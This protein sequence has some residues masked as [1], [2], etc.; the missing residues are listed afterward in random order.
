MSISYINAQSKIKDGRSNIK[1]TKILIK[2]EQYID[3][4]YWRNMRNTQHTKQ[5]NTQ[6]KPPTMETG[7]TSPKTAAHEGHVPSPVAPHCKFDTVDPFPTVHGQKRRSV[8]VT[9][10]KE[11]KA[12]WRVKTRRRALT[13]DVTCASGKGCGRRRGMRLGGTCLAEVG[14][15]A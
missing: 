12:L 9:R 14:G 15:C 6:H 1:P 7:L 10:A 8:A 2:F 4:M 13:I 3:K 11:Q 5:K